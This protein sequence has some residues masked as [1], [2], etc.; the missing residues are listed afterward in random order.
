M[1]IRCW[2]ASSR[3]GMRPTSFAASARRAWSWAQYWHVQATSAGRASDAALPQL[4][5]Q[6]HTEAAA[7]AGP[8]VHLDP[9]AVAGDDGVRD[10]Q[11]QA[12]AL[13]HRLGREERIEQPR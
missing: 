4:P 9:P 8:A 10:R 11:A 13:A 2:R 7:L 6:E 12:R 5:R 1:P 3:A